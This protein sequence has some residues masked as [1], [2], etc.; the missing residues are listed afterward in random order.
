MKL[1]ILNDFR[2]PVSFLII[3]DQIVFELSD[4]NEPSRDSLIDKRR[5]TSPAERIVVPINIF[6]DKSTSFF[7]IFHDDLIRIFNIFSLVS[8]Y[9]FGKDAVFIKGDWRVIRGDDFILHAHLVIVLAKTWR[10]M[11][12]AGTIRICDKVSAIN[13]K[14]SVFCSIQEE[15]KNRFILQPLK[16]FAF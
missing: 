8:R 13:S 4:S 12:N 1:A 5:V 3:F 11:N 2:N 15:I 7:Q 6:L 16:I 10:T 14:A 9:F